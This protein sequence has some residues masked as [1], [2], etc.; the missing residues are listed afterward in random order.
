MVST[1]TL[2]ALL[3]LPSVAY[4]FCSPAEKQK[5]PNKNL[6]YGT[7][8]HTHVPITCS[9]SCSFDFSFS[10]Y[11]TKQ[12]QKTIIHRKST[13]SAINKRKKEI[14]PSKVLENTSSKYSRYP[15]HTCLH[16]HQL[17]SQFSQHHKHQEAAEARILQS[18]RRL[19]PPPSPTHSFW[20]LY[21]YLCTLSKVT[22][23]MSCLLLELG[24]Q[25][26]QQYPQ[27]SSPEP[28][29]FPA[30]QY[31]MYIHTGTSERGK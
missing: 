7:F 26:C 2:T 6:V 16:Q 11:K 28:A 29:S 9:F 23:T 27:Q 22:V 30:T 20:R 14:K 3:N 13:A 1:S 21:L 24:G 15:I 10:N 25:P 19:L 12:K 4:V 5:Q 18:Y 17:S 31:M 8:E